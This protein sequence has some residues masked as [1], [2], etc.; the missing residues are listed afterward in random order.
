MKLIVAV[1]QPTRLQAVQEI[2][3]HLNVQRMTLLDVQEAADFDH[4][5]ML[6][7]GGR[8][9][10]KLLRKVILQ[11]VVNDDFLQRTLDAI[12][13]TAETQYQSTSDDGVVMVLPVEAAY[14]FHPLTE[15]PGAV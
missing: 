8:L 9:Q 15:G 10:A 4:P 13:S 11:I 7:Q 2:L 3:S 14:Q 1:I 12:Q 6:Y 5:L